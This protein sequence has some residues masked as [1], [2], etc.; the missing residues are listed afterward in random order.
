MK[1]YGVAKMKRLNDKIFSKENIFQEGKF[2]KKPSRIDDL[3]P[4][5]RKKQKCMLNYKYLQESSQALQLLEEEKSN[6][7]LG[8]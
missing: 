5:V 7:T 6:K 4:Q 2:K 1:N 3:Q 8:G